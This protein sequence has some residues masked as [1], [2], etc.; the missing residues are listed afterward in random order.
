MAR[1]IE[2]QP[3]FV[4]TEL[5]S[6]SAGER[7]H[8]GA[9]YPFKLMRVNEGFELNKGCPLKVIHVSM[10]M[11]KRKTGQVFKLVR[12]DDGIACVRIA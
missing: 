2:P 6:G 11:H 3:Q 5:V 7:P 10:S 4:I 12:Y 1:M 8:N 9:R